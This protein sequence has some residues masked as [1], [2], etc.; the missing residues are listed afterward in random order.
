[1]TDL[2]LRYSPEYHAYFLL[3]PS[4]KTASIAKEAGFKKHREVGHWYTQDIKNAVGV[5]Q[6]ADEKTRER[7]A[8]LGRRVSWSHAKGHEDFCQ[9]IALKS[10][11]GG[12]QY[13]PYQRV[14]IHLLCESPVALLAD[15]QGLGKTI[16]AIG[17]WN[18]V[19]PKHTLVI[20]PASVKLNWAREFLEWGIR[21]PQIHIQQGKAG[22]PLNRAEVTIINYDVLNDLHE[23][24]TDKPWD[25]VIIDEGQFLKNTQAKR[26]QAA[27][28]YRKKQGIVKDAKH[29]WILTGTPAPNRPIEFWPSL[30]RL[31][32][33]VLA[34]Y[35][36]FFDFGRH[37]CN[38]YQGKFGWDMSGASNT[39]ELNLRLRSS[40]MIRRLKA[41]VLPDLPDKQ[42]QVISFE[43]DPVAKKLIKE[44]NESAELEDMKRVKLQ[45]GTTV[46]D[47]AE[48][49]QKL[50]MLK[51]PLCLSHIHELL[52]GTVD[53]L[54]VFAH[55]AAVI[56]GL[57][58]GLKD[59][60][61]VK[62]DGRD[63]MTEKQKSVDTFQKVSSC[64][65]FIGQIQA[66]G[67][68]ITLTAAS[69]VV[70]VE[71]SWVAGDIAQAVDRCHRIGQKN[72]VLAQFLVIRGSLEE[73]MLR[74]VVDKQQAINSI[75]N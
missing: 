66:A 72:S 28:G 20:C 38:G 40:I 6:Y 13:K 71:S 32:P 73:Y 36:S 45:P 39:E 33:K 22:F 61:P 10:P 29:V 50:A 24:L 7:L 9:G 55:H 69:T 57:M 19:Q 15:E 62:L 43:P 21:E 60:A 63:S 5:I 41:D 42:Y 3:M 23:E 11:P 4:S 35:T 17:G 25:L 30:A 44:E 56:D 18:E 54:V 52:E 49:R 53:K 1:M 74:A 37:F 34:P 70:F 59:Y 67:V 48:L 68:G 14:G 65:V 8:S 26:T 75:I 51:L 16:Q 46:G 12:K 2:Q 31:A 64:R 58:N 27:L 47:I